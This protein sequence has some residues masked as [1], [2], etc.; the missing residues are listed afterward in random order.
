MFEKPSIADDRTSIKGSQ[1]D[2][3]FGDGEHCVAAP[4]NGFGDESAALT[5]NGGNTS[6]IGDCCALVTFLRWKKT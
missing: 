4:G 3:N 2:A 1:L 6:V 5:F